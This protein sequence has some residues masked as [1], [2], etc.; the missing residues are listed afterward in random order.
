M[1]SK[2][3]AETEYKRRVSYVVDDALAHVLGCDVK[4]GREF[5]CVF[6]E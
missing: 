6:E 5:F 2:T 1:N 4:D 3:A